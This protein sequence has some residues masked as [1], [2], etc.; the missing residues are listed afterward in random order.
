MVFFL[1]IEYRLQKLFSFRL[2]L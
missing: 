2:S 1:K